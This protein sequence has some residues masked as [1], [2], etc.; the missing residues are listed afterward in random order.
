MWGSTH[1]ALTGD[2]RA[3]AGRGNYAGP[4]ASEK[5]LPWHQRGWQQ[6][7]ALLNHSLRALAGCMGFET[8]KVVKHHTAP[9]MTGTATTMPGSQPAQG[10]HTGVGAA[11][12][13][14]VHP[15]GTGATTQARTS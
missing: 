11:I 13:N 1:R 12:S 3:H 9:A 14:L 15:H 10:H 7:G 6:H 4:A 2:G 5:P 8:R